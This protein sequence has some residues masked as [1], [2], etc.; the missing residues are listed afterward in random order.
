MLIP[1]RKT[2]SFVR[3]LIEQCFSSRQERTNRGVFYQNYFASGSADPTNASIYNKVYA[4]LDD[5]ESLLYSP[6]SLRFH[7]GDPDVSNVLNVAK[8]RAASLKLRNE[9]RRSDTDTLISAAVREALVKGKSLVK[10]LHKRGGF[11]PELVRPESFGVMRENHDRL[12]EDMEA[13]GHH[14]LITP[15]QFMRLVENHPDKNDLVKKAHKLTRETTGEMPDTQNGGMQVVVGGLYPFQ[16]AGVVPTGARGIVDWMAQP[17][18]Q[19]SPQVQQSLMDLYEMWV[20]DDEREDWTTFQMVG[21][22]I[23]V[24]GKYQHT[25]AIA[26]DP[27][28]QRTVPYLKGVHPFREFCVTPMPDYFWGWSEIATLIGLQEAINARI[29]GTNKMLRKQ[30]EPSTKFQ[31]STGVNQVTLARF[32]KPGGYWSDTNPNAK[33]ED[34]VTQ[35]PQDLWGSLHEYERMFDELMGIPPTARG[36]NEPG[37]RS[38][39]HANTLVR[40]FSPRFKDRALLVERS[41]EGVGGLMLD[42]AKA[43]DARKMTAWVPKE[44]AGLE[45][46]EIDPLLV[47]PA[48]GFVPVQFRFADLPESLTLTVDSHSSSPAF[49]QEEKGNNA[50][51]IKIGAMSPAEFVERSDVTDPDELQ[52]DLARREIAKAEAAKAELLAKTAGHHKH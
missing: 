43:H 28:S 45:V 44:M 40:Q 36:K 10:V 9:A 17:R 52:M 2:E 25:N 14:M 16:P 13:F 31:G 30:E 22:D 32:K 34:V 20:W 39:S 42:L 35:I 11:S 46:G 24:T 27:A 7:L 5:L 29:N 1:R 12:D 49:V 3:D 4:G 8:G 48:K 37:V 38:A 21:K 15:F 18:A 47:P 23:L 33:V 19:M 6:V 50:D 41:V 51:L 26:H